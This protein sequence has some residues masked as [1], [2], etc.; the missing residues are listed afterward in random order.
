MKVVHSFY[1]DKK[2]EL[3]QVHEDEV[4]KEIAESILK[5]IMN[6]KRRGEGEGK[7]RKEK[8]KEERIFL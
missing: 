4:A 8:V 5:D 3:R 1:E 6:T 2:A 7:D